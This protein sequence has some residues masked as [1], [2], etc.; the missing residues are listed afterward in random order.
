MFLL[1]K[2]PAD[3]HHRAAGADLQWKL[4]GEDRSC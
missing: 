3:V 1:G 2:D 4:P